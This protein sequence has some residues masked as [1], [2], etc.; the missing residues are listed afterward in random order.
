M[1]DSKTKKPLSRWIPPRKVL[2]SGAG[3]VVAFL[4][5]VALEV[6]AGVEIPMEAAMAV[7]AGAA[8][9]LGYLVPDS[10]KDVV[11]K[12]DDFLREIADE[13]DR[14]QEA[15]QGKGGA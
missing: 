14:R 4:A 11:N 12:G 2:A 15:G 8:T 5:T 7:V 13:R 1:A 3:A 6:V 10:V 9:L